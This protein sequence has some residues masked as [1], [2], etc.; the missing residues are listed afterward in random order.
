MMSATFIPTKNNRPVPLVSIFVNVDP[1]FSYI[2]TL[3]DSEASIFSI[4]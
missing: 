3:S 4:Q 1:T 2:V